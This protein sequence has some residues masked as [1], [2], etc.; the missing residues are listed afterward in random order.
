MPFDRM[1]ATN[2]KCGCFVKRRTKPSDGR[3]SDPNPSVEFWCLRS[4]WG[5]NFGC[6]LPAK[7][8]WLHWYSSHSQNLSVR[9]HVVRWSCNDQVQHKDPAWH[10]LLW[11]NPIQSNPASDLIRSHATMIACQPSS[12]LGC[13]Y[14]PIGKQL[15][16]FDDTCNAS[17]PEDLALPSLITNNLMMFMQ[18]FSMMRSCWCFAANQ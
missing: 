12:M 2:G 3:N 8:L 11:S 7:P 16:Q 14:A 18:F 5:T 4:N 10:N 17:Q 13:S 1:F 15:V 6:G 9:W